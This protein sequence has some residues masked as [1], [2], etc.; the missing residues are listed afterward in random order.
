MT[1]RGLALV[2][3]ALGICSLPAPVASGSAQTAKQDRRLASYC[4]PTG[5]FCQGVFQRPSGTVY[6]DLTT[7]SYRG[8]V[9]VCITHETRVCRSAH[10]DAQGGG[11]FRARTRWQAAYPDE[12]SG[13]Y[14]VAWLDAEGYRIGRR[15]AFQRP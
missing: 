11:L 5:D 6:T 12:G 14:V 7:F 2:A 13:R 10:L 8:R 4:T 3:L 1:A 15:L 9:D